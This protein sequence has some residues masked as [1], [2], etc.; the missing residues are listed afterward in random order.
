MKHKE[1]ARKLKQMGCQEIPR[2]GRGSY[3][4]WH[5]PTNGSIIPIPDWG[6]KDLKIGTLRQ[7]VRQL[8][9]DW[10]DFNSLYRCS[11]LPTMIEQGY[12]PGLANFFVFDSYLSI[13]I[14]IK[15]LL[16]LGTVA[17]AIHAR[18][19]IIPNLTGETLND[20]AFHIVGVTFLATRY[21]SLLE[22][23]YGWAE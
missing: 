14:S 10:N 1:V 3:R 22:Q 13:Y 11:I 5:N 8:G 4:K 23:E 16:L 21:S 12:F 2:K 9:L 20:L 6:G 15:F 19:F 17:L 7:I 18:F